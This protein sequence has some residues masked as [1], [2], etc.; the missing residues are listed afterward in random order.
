M[1]LPMLMMTIPALVGVLVYNLR[2]WIWVQA[3]LACGA[4]FILFVLVQQTPVDQLVVLA[5][6]DMYFRSSWEILGRSFVILPSDK[7]I[8]TSNAI[9]GF[10]HFGNNVRATIY[11]RCTFHTDWCCYMC[12]YDCRLQ[13]FGSCWGIKVSGFCFYWRTIYLNGWL[14]DGDVSSPPR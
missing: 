4:M 3:I 10:H 13:I 5:G 1:S 11:L 2:R 7:H 8:L 12:V 6:R 9:T 14:A